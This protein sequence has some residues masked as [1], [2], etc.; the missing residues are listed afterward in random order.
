MDSQSA[1]THKKQVSQLRSALRE[2]ITEKDFKSLVTKLVEKRK[3]VDSS[4]KYVTES[5][6]ER[7]GLHLSENHWFSKL[8]RLIFNAIKQVFTM[9]QPAAQHLLENVRKN[10]R[11]QA[12]ALAMLATNVKLALPTFDLAAGAMKEDGLE[13]L[14]SRLSSNLVNIKPISKWAKDSL[15]GTLLIHFV[16]Q[17]GLKAIA[18]YHTSLQ[19]LQLQIDAELGREGAADSLTER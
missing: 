18:Q 10:F 8:N 6:Y 16:A 12:K 4:F 19:K 17:D 5:H 14:L 13:R 11:E 2:K 15:R 9:R 3:Q 1:A 7:Y